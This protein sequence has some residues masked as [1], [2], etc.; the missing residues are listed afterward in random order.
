MSTNKRPQYTALFLIILFCLI[1]SDKSE[2]SLYS[3]VRKYKDNTIDK[4]AID[5]L[6][7]FDTLIRY[8][9]SF[10]Y[11]VPHHKTSPDF[12]RALILAESS[13]NPKAVSNKNAIGLGQIILTTGKQAGLELAKSKV[14]FRY[15][16]QNTLLHLKEKDLFD[17]AVNILLTCYLIAKYNYKFDGKL[18][19]VMT[20]WNAGENTESLNHGQHAPYKETEDLIGKVNSYYVYL[21]RNKIFQ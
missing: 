13:A 4:Q 7:E 3:S 11:F 9:T 10:S 2:G 12:I 20:A 19:L 21:L 6:S 16:S 1:F 17:P 5:R 15:V 14:R 8:F 18:H